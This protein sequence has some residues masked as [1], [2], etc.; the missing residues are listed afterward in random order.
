MATYEYFMVNYR[1]TSY[2]TTNYV[3]L[4]LNLIDNLTEKDF[5]FF[6]KY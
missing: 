5:Q 2:K 6:L 4:S 3:E 1:C